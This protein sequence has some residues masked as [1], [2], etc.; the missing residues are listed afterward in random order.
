M[1]AGELGAF[2]AIGAD[3]PLMALLAI[4]AYVCPASAA[5]LGAILIAKGLSP[6]A[7]LVAMTLGPATNVATLASLHRRYGARATVLGTGALVATA[8]AAALAVN[9]LVPVSLPELATGEAH[10]HGPLAA[11]AA[12]VFALVCLRAMWLAGPAAVLPGLAP[13]HPSGHAHAHAHSRDQ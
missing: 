1:P 3:I 12:G 13:A 10:A 6:G 7:V 8:W 9:A 11:I 4:P 2:A 5:P